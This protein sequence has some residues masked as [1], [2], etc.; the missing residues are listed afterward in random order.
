[1]CSP[2]TRNQVVESRRSNLWVGVGAF[3]LFDRS[4]NLSGE[5]DLS[6]ACR[7]SNADVMSPRL[8]K[9]TGQSRFLS[10]SADSVFFAKSSTTVGR[11]PE[12]EVSEQKLAGVR[13]LHCRA[14]TC[15]V[16]KRQVSN[17][18]RDIKCI[19]QNLELCRL[20]Q[21]KREKRPIDTS[22]RKTTKI[23]T[24]SLRKRSNSR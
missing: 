5:T 18:P 24:R 19:A 12:V 9:W 2:W 8:C 14:T 10:C 16:G 22:A 20:D 15:Y 6:S 13:L 4:Q 21:E 23:Q 11:R 7:I 3:S 1:M 17:Q